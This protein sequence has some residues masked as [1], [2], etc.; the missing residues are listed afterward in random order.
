MCT[1]NNKSSAV[2]EMGDRLTSI[3]MGWKDAGCCVFF[4][5]ELGLHLTQCHLGRG[6]GLPP[7]QV[8][9]WSTKRFGHK[10]HGPKIGGCATLGELDPHLTQ[11]KSLSP[12]Q[13]AS[14][15]IQA[16][17]HNAPTLQTGQTDRQRSDSIG[18]TVLQTVA[19]EANEQHSFVYWIR[20]W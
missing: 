3:D 12:Y 5:G 1:C 14:W 6:L 8:T 10:R 4:G 11:A 2:A 7:Y 16:L 20:T 9:S 18:R 13:V 15:S 19:Q 17:G